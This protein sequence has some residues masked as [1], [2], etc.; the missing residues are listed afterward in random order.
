MKPT[1]KRRP[2]PKTS[3]KRAK[4]R[5]VSVAFTDNVDG[6]WYDIT[7]FAKPVG[8]KTLCVACDISNFETLQNLIADLADLCKE[9][10]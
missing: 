8:G 9:S 7:R 3:T 10:S 1:H 4:K 5:L 2:L 6:S